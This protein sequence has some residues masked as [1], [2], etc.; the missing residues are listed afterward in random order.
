MSD[1]LDLYQQTSDY[2]AEHGPRIGRIGSRCLCTATSC[3]VGCR[4][5]DTRAALGGDCP[6]SGASL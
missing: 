2:I 4:V 6:A 3:V 5:C 1:P